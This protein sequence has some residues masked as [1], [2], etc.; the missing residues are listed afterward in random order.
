MTMAINFDDVQ[1]STNPEPRCPCVLLLDTSGSMAGAPISELNAGLQTF[2]RELATDRLA[3]LRVEIAIIGFGP[4]AVVQD[5]VTASH[6][7]PPTLQARGDT[8]LGTALN[9]ALD[10]LEQRKQ[11]YKQNGISYYR[12]WVFLITDGQP[13]DGEVWR[14]AA[15]HLQEAEGNKKL[16]FF[17]VGVEGAE[18][19]MLGQLSTRQ[20]LKLRGLSFR[21]LFTWL[22]SSLSS[23]SHSIPGETVPLQSPAGWG[24][25]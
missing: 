9:L 17:A 2:A 5:F 10:R 8:P 7:T 20:P 24:E 15:R 14:V 18:M 19:A 25:I 23:V 22:S 11:A 16:A 3:M 4:V 13:T 1:F 21:E 6:F 12:P